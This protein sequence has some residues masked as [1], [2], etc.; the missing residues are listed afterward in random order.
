[1]QKQ[2]HMC[3]FSTLA[4]L[5]FGF[6]SC[7]SENKCLSQTYQKIEIAEYQNVQARIDFFIE[8]L[9]TCHDVPGLSVAVIDDFEIAWAKGYGVE[10][11]ETRNPVTSNSL[12]EAASMSKTFSSIAALILANE[13]ALDLD[14]NINNYLEAWKV[15]DNEYTVNQKVTIRRILSHTAGLPTYPLP[16]YDSRKNA[17]SIND[18]IGYADSQDEKRMQPEVEPGTIT[19]YSNYGYLILQLM[20]EDVTGLEPYSI[21]QS[22]L[23]DPLG[24]SFSSY[25]KP[26][27]D[28]LEKLMV[29]GHHNNGNPIDENWLLKNES[30]CCGLYTTPSDYATLITEIQK[31]LHGRSEIIPLETVTQMITPVLDNNGLGVFLRD[32]G[33]YFEH[34]GTNRG[35]TGTYIAHTR[36]GYGIVIMMNSNIYHDI[37]HEIADYVGAL[38]EWEKIE[39]SI[40]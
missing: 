6:F 8:E 21:L 32:D 30:I 28:N 39:Y 33:A 3:S 26:L 20:F 17:P 12:F 16:S 22:R 29:S 24:L 40:E 27:P 11:T 18:L 37:C 10:N 14:S 5:F 19:R 25:E 2:R 35:F 15:P 4:I 23:L 36:D 34:C 9:M 7:A 1:M 38:Y 31:A 13:Y